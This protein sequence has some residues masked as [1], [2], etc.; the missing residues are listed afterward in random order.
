MTISAIELKPANFQTI[1]LRTNNVSVKDLAL[2]YE[3]MP[4]DTKWYVV[5]DYVGLDG[6]LFASWTTL[7]EPWLDTYFEFDTQKAKTQYVPV[8]KRKIPKESN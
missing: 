5:R 1:A 6:T 4:K 8:E 2:C 3:S 7:S